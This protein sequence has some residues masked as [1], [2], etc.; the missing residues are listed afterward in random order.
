MISAQIK[1]ISQRVDSIVCAPSIRLPFKYQHRIL[2]KVQSLLET[3]CFDF[4][5]EKTPHLMNQQNWHDAESIELAR[6][7]QAYTDNM[8]NLSLGDRKILPSKF[9][10]KI[11]DGLAKLRRSTVQRI[12]IDMAEMFGIFEAAVEFA[13]L[14]NGS[15]GAARILEIKQNFQSTRNELDQQQNVLKEKLITELTLVARQRT[16]LDERETKAI[17]AT[18]KLGEL[19]RTEAFHALGN[20]FLDVTIDCN[21]S[22]PMQAVMAKEAKGEEGILNGK[23]TSSSAIRDICP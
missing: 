21:L 18:Q 14:L 3:C 2:V 19:Q 22:A 8:N 4:G 17:E 13:R 20:S 5:N 12:S 16:E 7:I 10:V 6:W 1:S 15:K 9:P 11:H 23:K